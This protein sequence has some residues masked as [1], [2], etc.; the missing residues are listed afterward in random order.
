MT[1]SSLSLGDV[2]LSPAFASDI[3]TYTANAANEVESVTVT[4]EAADTAATVVIKLNG[5]A[6][7]DGTVELVE[8]DGNVITIDVTVDSDTATYTVTV[9]RAGAPLAEGAVLNSLSLSDVTLSEAFS[10]DTLNY[11]ASVVHGIASTTVK[12]TVPK[13]ARLGPAAASSEAGHPV[14]L[15]VG[16]NTIDIAVTA[17]D[18]TTFYEI[19]ITRGASAA[20][21]SL[22]DLS[23]DT[24]GVTLKPEFSRHTYRY[25]VT[26]PNS[27]DD[28]TVTAA[29]NTASAPGIV[30][31][32]GS[33][34]GIILENADIPLTE[35]G[36]TTIRVE[37]TSSDGDNTQTYTI[38]ITRLASAGPKDTTLAAL[39]LAD[40]ELDFTTS[41]RN[42]TAEVEYADAETTV[43]W[44]V[45]ANEA[46]AQVI[47]NGGTQGSP[48]P[49]GTATAALNVGENFILVRVTS[50]DD[51]AVQDYEVRVTREAFEAS[52]DATLSGIQ[53]SP[54]LTLK[55]AFNKDVTSYTAGV[56][57]SLLSVEVTPSVTDAADED[58]GGPDGVATF[59]VKP[60]DDIATPYTV[61]LKEGNTVITIEVTAEDETTK[62][63]YS[64]TVTREGTS[65][66]DDATLQLLTLTDTTDDTDE[67][68]NHKPVDL[69]V[70]GRMTTSY[71]ATVSFATTEV[72]I[73]GQPNI[74]ASG[75]VS[76]IDRNDD[77]DVDDANEV[78]NNNVLELTEAGEYEIVVR[79]TT[80][81]TP[82]AT[83]DYTI[84]L[85]RS[86]RVD[87]SDATLSALTVTVDGNAVDLAPE[88]H[89]NTGPYKATVG[90]LVESATVA[91]TVTD[92]DEATFEITPEDA[93]DNTNNGHQVE[94]DEGANTIT[95]V[96]T[97]ED[98]TTKT[99][100]V[101]VTRTPQSTDSSLSALT[102]KVGDDDVDL[103]STFSADDT[104]YSASIASTVTAV[105]LAATRSAGDLGGTVV[106]VDGGTITVS[107]DE[108]T[109]PT[110]A[111]AK[112]Y[113]IKVTV[114]AEDGS[115]TIYEIDLVKS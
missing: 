98:G 87:S 93:D 104:R 8:G 78:I 72:T 114:T 88:F 100:T 36:I 44:T 28:V 26:V 31:R 43:A 109:V 6:D 73:F 113:T 63:V 51:L 11:T 50:P 70:F 64:I 5:T 15:D 23:L 62:K 56:A 35:G 19:V 90:K 96:V 29:G 27:V 25:T 41:N 16:P 2:G 1:L 10:P 76:R 18:V 34:Q 61:G 67:T 55:P 22:S 17:G 60:S 21:A 40:I 85:T 32:V 82:M 9:T 58:E 66:A 110:P 105:T 47:V 53:F 12:V 65:G 7:D 74:V 3:T 37:V 80:T 103:D 86:A 42:Y 115:M 92:T 94:F 112:T 99:Y 108:Y 30:Y 54:A 52:D 24:T 33:G 106:T 81:G 89:T 77:G 111:S 14:N 102:L 45:N 46:V 75:Y 13:D 97:A 83:M 4:V 49:T 48:G 38:V 79:V 71:T 95:I 20:D 69:G 101:T 57:A 59:V 84:T 39:S 91:P 107:N 68:A